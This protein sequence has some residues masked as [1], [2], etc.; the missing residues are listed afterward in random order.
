[1]IDLEKLQ[2]ALQKDLASLRTM[3]DEL[4]LQLA[5]GKADARS[6][7]NHLE[8]RLERAEEEIGRVR[9][10]AEAAI[11]EIEAGSRKLLGELKTGYELLRQQ[12]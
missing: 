7:W 2:T 1:M 4:Q 6:E 5:L 12:L 9:T 8:A 11:S 10:H 3:R